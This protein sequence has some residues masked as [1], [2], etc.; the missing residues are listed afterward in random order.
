MNETFIRKPDDAGYIVAWRH[1]YEHVA[2]RHDDEVITYRETKAKA[3]AL[4]EQH[5]DNILGGK[6]H[7]PCQQPVLQPGCALVAKDPHP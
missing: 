3:E 7:G 6:T 4:C 2:G 5:K 1:K